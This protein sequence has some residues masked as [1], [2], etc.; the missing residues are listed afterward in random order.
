M[1]MFFESPLEA[2][3]Q[4]LGIIA[5]ILTI[6]CYQFNSQKK[7]L[8]IQICCAVL[9]TV[10]L[11]LLGKWA[12][13][14]LNIHGIAR[15]LVFY[16]RGRHKWAESNGWVWLFCVLAG[17]CVALTALIKGSISFL[18]ILPFVGTVFSTISL[19][20]TDPKKIRRFMLFSPPCWF[21]YHLLADGTPNIGG[22]LNEIFVLASI[23][24]AMFRYDLKKTGKTE[25]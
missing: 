7:I 21:T 9:F 2:A 18:D 19:S 25:D 4:V 13:S 5:L 20:Q 1:N 8:L 16:Q 6:I 24:V 3:A 14:L 12:G 15:A 23:L 17:V 10:N 22:V 11:A